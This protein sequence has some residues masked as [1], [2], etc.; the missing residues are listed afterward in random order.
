MVLVRTESREVL[1]PTSEVPIDGYFPGRPRCTYFLRWS[2]LTIAVV[3]QAAFQ[4]RRR[5]Q[6]FIRRYPQRSRAMGH[7]PPLS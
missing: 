1:F 4:L 5:K 7:K 2:K 6:K 3:I